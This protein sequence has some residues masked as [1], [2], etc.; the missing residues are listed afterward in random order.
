M[1]Q[2]IRVSSDLEPL[3]CL[4]D[5][6]WYNIR[7]AL[8]VMREQLPERVTGHLL[9]EH[10]ASTGRPGVPWSSPVSCSSRGQPPLLFCLFQSGT[11]SG[12][13]SAARRATHVTDFVL[14][15]F[16]SEVAF[17]ASNAVFRVHG[18]DESTHPPFRRPR[19]V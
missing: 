19:R 4:G 18:C 17:E 8:W 2:N 3:G 12:P 16:G 1:T 10:G 7:F 5:L 6:G 13:T 14:P 11:S 9:A 15:Y